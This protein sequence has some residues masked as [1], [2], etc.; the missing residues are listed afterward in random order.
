MALDNP[1]ETNDTFVAKTADRASILMR[2]QGSTSSES[3]SK[4]DEESSGQESESD[5]DTFDGDSAPW[6]DSSD[7]DFDPKAAGKP[8]PK[9]KPKPPIT[10]QPAAGQPANQNVGGNSN[11]VTKG[12]FAGSLQFDCLEAPEQC[13][14]V[15]WYQN[16][17]N[18]P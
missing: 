11:G 10:S 4:S 6:D 1:K 7:G 9:S 14:N 3:E 12:R 8:K 15:C 17:V 13:Q 18:D 16:C 5:D 2:R